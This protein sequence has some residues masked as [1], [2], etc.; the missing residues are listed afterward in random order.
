MK[1]K[2]FRIIDIL[3]E[4]LYFLV[5]TFTLSSMAASFHFDMIPLK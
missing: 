1:Q 3:F 2:L 5:I 4:S